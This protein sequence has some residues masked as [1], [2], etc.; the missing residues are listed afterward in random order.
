MVDPQHIGV[1]GVQEEMFSLIDHM[2]DEVPDQHDAKPGMEFVP[3]VLIFGDL[4]FQ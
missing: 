3:P 2:I 4:Q 1:A